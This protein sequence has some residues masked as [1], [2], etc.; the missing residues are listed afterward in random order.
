MRLC[1]KC[2]DYY[3]D[4]LLA[5]CLTDGT[6]LAGVVPE[7]E[8]WEEGLRVVEEK[9]RVLRVRRR[10][11]KWQ[12]VTQVVTTTLVTTMVVCVVAVNGLIY[13][14]PEPDEAPA[15]PSG[16]TP[17]RAPTPT[18]VV[19]R[20]RGWIPD[21]VITRIEP[22]P[23]TDTEGDPS[24]KVATTT[25][26]GTHVRDEDTDTNENGNKNTNTNE[27]TNENTNANANEN[28]NRNTNTNTN[29]NTNTNTNAN[30]DTNTNTNA[31]TGTNTN[32]N[33]NTNRNTNTN[34][35]ADTPVECSGADEE[36][37]WETIRGAYDGAWRRLLG[38]GREQILADPKTGGAVGVEVSPG[39]VRY[40]RRFLNVCT[41]AVVS[42]RYTWD[43]M[44][45]DN[46]TI[47]NTT[48]TKSKRFACFKLG[49][50]WICR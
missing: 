39:E 2:G 40:Q 23:T 36:R 32:E 7:G 37:E 41:A 17:K 44:T 34:T 6:P 35:N 22:L 46:G 19:S 50:A 13:L 12:R 16:T 49:G 27:N 15:S 5:F 42:A 45:N 33:R 4:D 18:T 31:N 43:V 9:E 3:A 8:L 28:A 47:K 29:E 1:P 48:V 11:L 26:S 14:T 21:S 10:R 38:R 30:T 25:S 20:L 24:P